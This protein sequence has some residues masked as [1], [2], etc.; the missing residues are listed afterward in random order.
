MFSNFCYGWPNNQ[1]WIPMRFWIVTLLSTYCMGLFAQEIVFEEV[2]PSNKSTSQIDFGHLNGTLI[3][4]HY[5][6]IKTSV[7]TSDALYSKE[8]SFNSAL[9]LSVGMQLENNRFHGYETFFSY[10]LNGIKVKIGQQI[11]NWARIDFFSP[12]ESLNTLNFEN[13][14]I[15]DTKYQKSGNVAL[16]LDY[17]VFKIF[18]MP[19]KRVSYLPKENS[20][21]SF[22]QNNALLGIEKNSS[23]SMLHYENEPTKKRNFSYGLRMNKDLGQSDF[24]FSFVHGT[25]AYPTFELQGL[26]LIP[27]FPVVNIWSTDFSTS[28]SDYVLR[29]EF[30]FVQGTSITKKDFTKKEAESFNSALGIEGYPFQSP[31]KLKVTLSHQFID[32]LESVYEQKEELTGH[33]EV[34]RLFINDKL[35]VNVGLLHTVNEKGRGLSFHMKYNLNDNFQ[36]GLKVIDLSGSGRGP[37][38]FYNNNRSAH[39]Y[40]E[41]DL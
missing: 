37:I 23:L 11:I 7:L 21:W 9:A 31:F 41:I 36:M 15:R 39:A 1:R 24:G 18:I 13:F 25:Q 34:E 27:V 4:S 14:F 40:I 12:L 35:L 16:A 20:Q 8:W 29:G 38:A 28:L 2:A 17:S 5:K 10:E 3:L 22:F 19:W 6:E 32:S 30:S 33:Y 26:K